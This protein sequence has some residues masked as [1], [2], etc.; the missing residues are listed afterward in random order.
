MTVTLCFCDSFV[1][2]AAPV[3]SRVAAGQHMVKV[4]KRVSFPLALVF[5][6]ILIDLIFIGLNIKYWLDGSLTPRFDVTIDKSYA[7]KF[8]YLKW[9]LCALAMLWLFVREHDKLYVAWSALFFYLYAD[10]SLR[11]H[12]LGGKVVTQI[13][14]WEGPMFGVRAQDIGE[15][16]VFGMAGGI[17][18]GAVGAAYWWSNSPAA[19]SL[20][21]WLVGGFVVF[22]CFAVVADLAHIVLSGNARFAAGIIEDGGEMIVAS[23]LVYLITTEM[24][25]SWAHEQPSAVS[26]K[27]ASAPSS[28]SPWPSGS[29]SYIRARSPR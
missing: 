21:R 23:I 2:L 9:I 22:A 15:L 13:A 18:L 17:L 12:E 28:A 25:R 1:N 14:G 10:D 26:Q 29:E 5:A 6:L 19:K 24:S 7:E 4:L 20:S 8:N 3:S 11:L 16:V 27:P